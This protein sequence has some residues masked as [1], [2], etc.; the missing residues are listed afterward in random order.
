[1]KKALFFVIILTFALAVTVLASDKISPALDVIASNHSMVK[2]SVTTNN[3][4]IF[5]VDDFDKP[6]G[7]NLKSITI[8]ELPSQSAGRLMLD[9]L[10]VVKNQVITRDDFSLLKFVQTTSEGI[11][12]TFKFKPNDGAYEIECALLPLDSVNLSPVATNG[13]TVSAWTNMNISCFGTLDGYDPEGERLRYEIVSYPEK[14]LITLTNAE[15]GDYKYTPFEN[16]SGTDVFSYTVRD[17]K[18][19]YSE[20]C[21]VKMKIEK[22]KTS[23]VFSDLENERCLNAAL[24]MY[25]DNLMTFKRN[26]DGTFDFRPNEE[27]T[28]EE[29]VS[30][31]MKAMG[32]RD[33]PIVEKTRFADDADISPEYKGYLESAFS[34]GIIKGNTEAD[35]VHINPKS[36]V[37][38]AEAAMIINKIIGAK[39]QT[40]M[41]VFADDDQIPD[42][43]RESLTSLT[44]LGILEKTNGKISPNE[45]L[46]RAQTAQIIMSL[47]EYR[48][49]LNK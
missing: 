18:G 6:L 14:G 23:L 28:K 1:M 24:V 3:E 27:I 11:S 35:G 46:T 34:L 41:T 25:E 26:G 36:T 4:V 17:E 19:N 15:T 48:G 2:S 40:S 38:T 31:V 43:A 32:A 16:A 45:T 29:F 8:T 22:L 37:T 42:S 47:L 12:A 44:E 30:L 5:D 10:Y 39:I 13:S 33:V 9:N 49:K 21:T 7:V 20:I